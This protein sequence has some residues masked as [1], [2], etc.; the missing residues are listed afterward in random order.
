LALS[1]CREPL[2]VG[3]NGVFPVARRKIK[4]IENLKSKNLKKLA[5]VY[6]SEP[7]PLLTHCERVLRMLIHT[8]KGG[9]ES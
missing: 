6:L 7:L 9:G 3:S 5:G 8:G 4:L 2:P 1:A